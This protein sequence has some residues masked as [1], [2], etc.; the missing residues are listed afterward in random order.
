MRLILSIHAEIFREGQVIMWEASRFRGYLRTFKTPGRLSGVK[1]T[2]RHHTSFAS[3][4]STILLSFTAH[5]QTPAFFLDGFEACTVSV[6]PEAINFGDV[7]QGTTSPAKVLEIRNDG[8]DELSLTALDLLPGTSAQFRL[9]S[10]PSLP[11]PIAAGA[12]QSVSLLLQGQTPGS[13]NGNLLVGSDS[14]A[15]PETVVPVTGRVLACAGDE[16][17]DVGSSCASGANIGPLSDCGD[18]GA[19]K[20]KSRDGTLRG[21]NDVD[22]YYFFAEDQSRFGCDNFTDSFGIKVELVDAPN[23][24]TFCYR[25]RSGG[26]GG[27][28]GRSCGHTSKTFSVGS[29]GSNDSTWVTLWVEWDSNVAPQC[30]SYELK[31]RADAG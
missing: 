23:G 30:G 8:V 3:L 17:G 29:F 24:V 18:D 4:A 19:S 1:L 26:C 22:L 11:T 5:A 31:V 7:V 14:S 6:A 10:V 13:A 28:S 15:C 20:S 27:T 21:S 12:E 16:L 25:A 9:D 2:K